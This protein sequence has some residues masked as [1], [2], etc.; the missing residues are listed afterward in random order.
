MR[1]DDLDPLTLERAQAGDVSCQH[2]V[3]EAC[4]KLNH[5][6]S[7]LWIKRSPT[8]DIKDLEQQGVLGVYDAIRM[9]DPAKGA[10]PRHVFLWMSHRVR[11]WVLKEALY[12]ERHPFGLDTAPRGG[13]A[14]KDDRAGG[15]RVSEAIAEASIPDGYTY[16]DMVDL[17]KVVDA[18]ALL[19]PIHKAAFEELVINCGSAR[20]FGASFGHTQQWATKMRRQAMKQVRSFMVSD[21]S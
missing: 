5:W 6:M 1:I 15:S 11:Q 2:Q 21:D 20:E 4:E 8:L 9:F 3:V 17:A 10:F 7:Y 12:R 16:E 19:D 13:A 14:S 18:V